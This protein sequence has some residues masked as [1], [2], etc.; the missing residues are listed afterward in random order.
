VP[1]NAACRGRCSARPRANAV[2]GPHARVRGWGRAGASRQV[3]GI[4]YH[5]LRDGQTYRELGGDYFD[6]LNAARRARLHRHVDEVRS[7]TPAPAQ[8]T[9][10]LPRRRRWSRT[11]ARDEDRRVPIADDATKRVLASGQCGGG[12]FGGVVLSWTLL[13]SRSRRV[14]GLGHTREDGTGWRWSISMEAV[15][16]LGKDYGPQIPFITQALAARLHSF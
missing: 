11:R 4:A 8:S 1:T 5:V 9:E 3:L 2:A 12:A 16:A 13:R 14:S 7:M 15:V 6:Q 10:D